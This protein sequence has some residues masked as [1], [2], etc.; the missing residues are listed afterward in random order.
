[1]RSKRLPNLNSLRVF[2]AAARNGSF[3]AA[4]QELNVTHGAISKQIQAL[5]HELDGK[6]F[7]RRNRG[8][9][10]TPSGRWLAEQMTAVFG[11]LSRTMDAF[12]SNAAAASPLTV[13]CEST[14][15]L[16]FLIPV[17]SLLKQ[18]TDLDIRV[19][20]AGGPIDF[21]P[22]YVDVAIR[23]GDFILPAG[24]HA[25][26]LADEWMGPVMNPLVNQPGAQEMPRLHSE[27]RPNAWSNWE[28]AT[29]QSY[30]GSDIQYE[31]F[32]LAIQAAEAGQGVALAS[33]HM[34]KNEL[35]AGRLIA[36][37]GFARDG[38]HYLALRPHGV[39]DDRVDRF[40]AW[41]ER[42]LGSHVTEEFA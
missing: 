21:R 4:A 25:T 35:S 10:L 5:E 18:E 42:R 14:L 9:Y 16:R 39:D 8:I 40:L 20:A 31:H 3:V 12:H 15:C 11:D 6:L 13:S 38:S 36:P 2:E 33:I 22:G 19:L 7:E 29:G 26:W 27:S 32:F 34:V 41:L 23:R 30:A 17:V 28:L 1:M 24:V 37:H